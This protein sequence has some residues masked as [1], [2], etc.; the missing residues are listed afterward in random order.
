MSVPNCS[1]LL[2]LDITC[3][4][5][6]R[7]NGFKG[8]VYMGFRADLDTGTA[9]GTNG[10][11]TNIALKAGKKLTKYTGIN[12]RHAADQSLKP[13]KNI[14]M[15]IQNV[16]LIL[17]ASTQAEIASIEKLAKA[18]RMFC[19]TETEDGQLMAYGIDKNPWVPTDLDD[20]RGLDVK[21]LKH[22]YGGNDINAESAYET[23][24]EGEFFNLAKV[25]NVDT[26]LALSI[27]ELDALC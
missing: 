8:R 25:V 19:I 5:E 13:G 12:M 16:K 10:N 6:R 14:N 15:F 26:T 1:D 23:E 22:A 3:A 27:T 20:E 7:P 11:I 24:L 4:A 2:A 18:Y 21:S 17:F 9:F